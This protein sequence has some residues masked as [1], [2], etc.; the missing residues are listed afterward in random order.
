ML[1]RPELGAVEEGQRVAS[2]PAIDRYPGTSASGPS[3]LE[4]YLP[5][6]ENVGI[7]VGKRVY[8]K[9]QVRGQT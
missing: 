9:L 5:V 8:S 4:Q 3:A 6:P 2:R 1:N 7:C